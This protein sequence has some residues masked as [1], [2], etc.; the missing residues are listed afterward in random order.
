MIDKYLMDM[1]VCPGCKE[2][3]VE[4]NNG[5]KCAKCGASY[6]VDDGIPVLLPPATFKDI[7]EILP[8]WNEQWARTVEP[9]PGH[10]E[11]EPDIMSAYAHVKKHFDLYPSDNF[12]EAGCG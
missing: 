3:L 7:G 11:M 5:L 4:E 1:L 6:G 9:V 12:M 2:A 10:L 8:A